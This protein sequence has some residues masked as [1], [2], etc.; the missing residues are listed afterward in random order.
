MNLIAKK[1]KLKRELKVLSDELEQL[2][3]KYAEIVKTQR[4]ELSGNPEDIARAAIDRKTVLE[5]EKLTHDDLLFRA[6]INEIAADKLHKAIKGW[7]E[8]NLLNQRIAEA[9]VFM[10]ENIGAMN[11]EEITALKNQIKSAISTRTS[12][13]KNAAD[14]RHNKPGGSRDKQKQI[15]AIW[16]TGK[17]NSKD[18]CAEQECA[19]LDMSFSAARKALRNA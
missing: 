2:P 11:T 14:A 9:A 12:I 13:A 19:A 18:V 6:A 5:K 7:E 16:A 10:I 3:A 17:Y 1:A 4:D 8:M 15:L